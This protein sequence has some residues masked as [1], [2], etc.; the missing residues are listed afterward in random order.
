ME[1]NAMYSYQQYHV[2]FNGTVWLTGVL[3]TK[4]EDK[5]IIVYHTK[6]NNLKQLLNEVEQDMRNY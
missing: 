4:F 1:G 6:N 2:R 3:D 5:R